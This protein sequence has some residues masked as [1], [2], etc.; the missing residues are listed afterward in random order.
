MT[1][2]L[3]FRRFFLFLALLLAAAPP[4]RA[5]DAK[6]AAAAVN[7]FYTEYIAQMDLDKGGDSDAAWV[8]RCPRLTPEFKA[9]YARTQR[10]GFDADPIFDAQDYGKQGV[11][12]SDTLEI[13]AKAG[14]LRARWVETG[15]SEK[16]FVIH[17]RKAGGNWLIHR[18]NGFGG[19]VPP[20]ARKYLPERG[21]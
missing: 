4:A 19:T 17:V 11:R 12:V 20:A 3:L 1:V 6:D 13:N 2:P 15:F 21:G 18:I 16:P 10:K 8:A 5:G 7:A 9:A 14:V